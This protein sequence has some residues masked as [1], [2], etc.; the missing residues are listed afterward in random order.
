MSTK[1]VRRPKKST[2]NKAAPKL[3]EWRR[4]CHIYDHDSRRSVCGTATRR[5]DR[6]HGEEYCKSRGH[7]VC[8]VCAEMRKN[9]NPTT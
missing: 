3:P 5:A 1:T 8:V 2:T 6:G 4:I 9:E 7:S